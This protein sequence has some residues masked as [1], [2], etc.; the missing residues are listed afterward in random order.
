MRVFLF[1]NVFS[2]FEGMG[3]GHTRVEVKEGQKITQEY[4]LALERY[5]KAKNGYLT[6]TVTGFQ[7]LEA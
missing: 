5:C 2:G 3:N 1:F 7:E 6:F 4:I